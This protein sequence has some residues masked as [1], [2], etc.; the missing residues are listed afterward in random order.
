MLIKLF[1]MQIYKC[2]KFALLFDLV[3]NLLSR[4]KRIACRLSVN[5]GISKGVMRCDHVKRKDQVTVS[6]SIAPQLSYKLWVL[7]RNKLT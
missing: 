5:Q 1:K 3:A 2:I 6:M 4:V 7:G